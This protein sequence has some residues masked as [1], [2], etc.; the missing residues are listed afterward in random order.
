MTAERTTRTAVASVVFGAAALLIGA[1]SAAQGAWCARYHT[2]GANCHFSSQ[3]QCL[4]AVSGVGG[5]C[6]EMQ[7]AAPA[8]TDEQSERP[9]RTQQQSQQS[10][11]EKS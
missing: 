4:Q 6:S 9:R 3:Q 7:T 5:V 11:Q 2:G 10:K 8:E 1:P